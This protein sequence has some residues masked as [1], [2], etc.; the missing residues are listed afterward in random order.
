MF[1]LVIKSRVPSERAASWVLIG[2]S[3]NGGN[4]G[5]L[6]G[7]QNQEGSLIKVT[8]LLLLHCM[9]PHIKKRVEPIASNNKMI[10][11]RGGINLQ[12][13]KGR[14]GHVG[15]YHILSCPPSPV[16]KCHAF[17]WGKVVLS[18]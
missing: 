4:D 8:S 17:W 1:E 15:G 12:E 5:H 6:C 16:P 2:P 7:N 11:C 10:L 13:S 18:G 3:P 14:V 9:L